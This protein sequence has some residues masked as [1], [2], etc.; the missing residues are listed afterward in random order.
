MLVDM[1]QRLIRG[2]VLPSDATET[3][4][5]DQKTPGAAQKFVYGDSKQFALIPTGY[6][7]LRKLAMESSELWR[8]KMIERM[9]EWVQLN[10]IKSYTGKLGNRMVLDT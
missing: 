9:M 2:G 4:I 6:D 7:Y 8:N 1:Q 5:M 10:L 3:G